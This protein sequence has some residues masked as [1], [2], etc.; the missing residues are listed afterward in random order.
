MFSPAL[1][2]LSVSLCA[3]LLKK[4]AWIWMKCCM[5]TDVGTWM[6]LLTFE[7]DLDHSPDAGTGLLP[8]I[9]YRLQN[10]AALPS[11]AYF[12]A[13]SVSICAKL[14]CSI[15]M[16]D[17]NTTTEPNFRKMFSKC[18]ILSPKN[19]Y[20]STSHVNQQQCSQ[21]RSISNKRPAIDESFYIQS[22]CVQIF[23]KFEPVLGTKGSCHSARNMFR[24]KF[25]LTI[26]AVVS[27]KPV[28]RF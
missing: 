12:S 8:P 16:T 20:L 23:N 11:L 17:R 26:D 4:Y 7:P 24:N 22:T 10:I 18:R 14:T 5:L 27:R 15:I 13:T 9:S 19:S 28:V 3:R 1:I 21:P 6:N 25:T 2:C